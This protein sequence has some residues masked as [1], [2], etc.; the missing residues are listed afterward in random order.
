MTGENH[1][2]RTSTDRGPEPRVVSWSGFVICAGLLVVFAQL[3]LE[4][5]VQSTLLENVTPDYR[6]VWKPLGAYYIGLVIVIVGALLM[7]Y[8]LVNHGRAAREQEKRDQDKRDATHLRDAA[9]AE[10]RD[11]ENKLDKEK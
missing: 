11:I 1:S 10:K 5:Q 7:A 8:A 6:Y 3:A 9:M 2:P 4:R